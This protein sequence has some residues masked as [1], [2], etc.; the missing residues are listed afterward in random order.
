MHQLPKLRA[1]G[2]VLLVCAPLS[3][4]DATGEGPPSPPE[5]RASLELG[6][7]Q[8]T[9]L[10]RA[11][12]LPLEADDG[13]PRADVFHVDYRLLAP[14]GALP[15][16]GGRPVTF[17]FNGG[18]GSSAVWLH[19]G[20]FGPRRVDL[21]PDGLSGAGPGTLFANEGSILDVTDLVF[22]DPVSTGHSRA[23]QGVDAHEFHGVDEDAESVGEFIRLWLTRN[24]RWASPR[25]LCGESYGTTR[26]A[27]LAAHLQDERGIELDG[28]IL[29]SSVLNFGTIRFA[30]G[31]DLPFVLYLP[32]YAATAWYHGKLGA[33]FETLDQVLAQAEEFA[34]GPYASALLAGERLPDGQ[35]QALARQL[36]ALT[37]L[38][39]EYLRATNLRP[40]IMR[41]CKELLRDERK[42]VG[43]LDAR[44][45]GRD[46]DA[47]GETYEYDPSYAA[48][49]G[50][51]TAG[52][53]D[54]LRRELG[55]TGEREYAVL[56]GA[57]QPWKYREPN[58]TLNVAE[59]LRAALAR[60]PRLRVF[61]ASGVYD[62]ATPYFATRYTFDH[63][64]LEGGSAARVVHARYE[65]G[66]ML[67]IRPADRRALRA[68]LL[69][70]YAGGAAR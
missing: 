46:R 66:H 9:Y 53:N 20:A 41:F 16:P 45:T 63:L 61:V 25:Y 31:N 51:F 59:D 23:V 40:D 11:A 39:A 37:G 26:A 4:Q 15:E 57:V 1:G 18:P 3:A 47:A 60:N 6:G 12:T 70:F 42:T 17:V 58:S 22:I 29:V 54:Y 52:L 14:D 55:W 43:R 62:L 35:Q 50:P 7:V 5:A 69:E 64:G 49:Q 48:I 67:Y 65:S 19:M 33:G 8:H 56:T 2:L 21:G 13:T 32:T 10:A 27:V 30:A 34:L 44:F 28:V 38:D 24:A 36:A 68:D